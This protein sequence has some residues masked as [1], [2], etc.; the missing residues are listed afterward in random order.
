MI[1]DLEQLAIREK[2]HGTAS[3]DR[4][5]ILLPRPPIALCGRLAELLLLRL[6]TFDLLKAQN[7]KPVLH[8]SI[9]NCGDVCRHVNN[10][11][12]IRM[13][14]E[15]LPEDFVVKGLRVEYRVAAKLGDSLTPTLSQIEN[16]FI[17]ALAMGNEAS[18]I[19]EFTSI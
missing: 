2:R 14:M 9:R 6:H 16:G 11:N 4:Q 13:A 12:Y 5:L 18:A 10:A 8:Q 7:Y 1:V 17:I 15:L 19:V 3:A